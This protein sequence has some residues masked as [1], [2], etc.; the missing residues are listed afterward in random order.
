MPQLRDPGAAA[1]KGATAEPFCE[2]CFLDYTAAARKDGA[3]VREQERV[4]KVASVKRYKCRAG[5][6]V[7]L[8]MVANHSAIA[9]DLDWMSKGQMSAVGH[10]AAGYAGA[11]RCDRVVDAAV[12]GAFLSKTFGA[13][14]FSAQEVAAVGKVITGTIALQAVMIPADARSCA[15]IRKAFGPGGTDI[16]GLLD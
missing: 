7:A 3:D 9:G 13:R 12:A 14:S 6:L 8:A 1:E 10:L 4:V 11:L 5:A 16:P 15:T 2:S